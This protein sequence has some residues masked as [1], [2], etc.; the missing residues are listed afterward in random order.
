[1][2]GETGCGS[3]A[4]GGDDG[5][6]CHGPRPSSPVGLAVG[7][8]PAQARP[9]PRAPDEARVGVHGAHAEGRVQLHRLA[10][11]GPERRRPHRRHAHAPAAVEL[12]AGPV[13]M[14]STRG[15]RVGAHR[16]ARRA[17][18]QREAVPRELLP[19][20]ARAGERHEGGD[21]VPAQRARYGARGVRR[22]VAGRAEVQGASRAELMFASFCSNRAAPI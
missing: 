10:A 9:E 4:A 6:E 8:R 22:R 21:R 13:R 15:R 11:Q 19:Y 17:E 3:S 5:A 1:M 14:A 16:R 18:R 12:A 20:R 7:R 2:A